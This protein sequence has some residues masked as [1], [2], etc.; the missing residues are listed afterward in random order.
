MNTT[1]LTVEQ[2]IALGKPADVAQLNSEGVKTYLTL[3]TSLI[4]VGTIHAYSPSSLIK[5]ELYDTLPEVVQGKVDQASII[6]AGYIRTLQGLLELGQEESRQVE[7]YV[8][9]IW[10]YKERYEKEIGDIFI[11]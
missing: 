9:H 3:L 2:Q 6:L 7:H 10:S 5:K 4:E 1:E 11:I 8:E